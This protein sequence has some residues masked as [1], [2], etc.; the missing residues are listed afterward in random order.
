MFRKKKKINIYIYI[1]LNFASI[2]IIFKKNK[3]FYLIK[4]IYRSIVLKN[5]SDTPNSN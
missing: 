3:Y 2:K 4:N 1:I 5:S